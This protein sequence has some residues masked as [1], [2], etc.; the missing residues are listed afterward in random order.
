LNTIGGILQIMTRTV[1]L[2][3]NPGIRYYPYVRDSRSP[4]RF[5]DSTVKEKPF[6]GNSR[7]NIMLQLDN[8]IDAIAAGHQGQ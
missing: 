8:G 4:T 3:A 7:Q 2:K 5:T 6:P 1:T